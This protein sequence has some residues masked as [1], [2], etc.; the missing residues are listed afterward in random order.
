MSLTILADENM[1]AVEQAFAELGE[2]RTMPGR[3]MRNSDLGDVDVL[4]VRSVTRVD[5]QLLDGTPVRFVGTATSGVDHIRQNYL[6][7]HGIHFASAHGA[8]ANSVVEY[9]LAAI[10][11][12]GDNLEALLDGAS[13]GIIGHGA[14]GSLLA[15]R[16][17]ALGIECRAYD[18]WLDAAA[19]TNAA[20]LE[21]VLRSQVISVH[22][23]LSDRPPWPSRHL[24]DENRLS[25]LSRDQL[26]V[27]ASRGPVVDNRALVQLLSAGAGPVPV[28]DVWEQEP[29]IDPALLELVLLGTSHIAGYSYDSKVRATTM[30]LAACYQWLQ[31][32]QAPDDLLSEP[33]VVRLGELGE[34]ADKAALLRALLGCR[35]D[36]RAD[37]HA[38]RQVVASGDIGRGFDRLRKEYPRRRELAGSTISAPAADP[39]VLAGLCHALGCQSL[40]RP[41]T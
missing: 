31:R 13:V 5:S 7:A 10:A 40:E 8:N 4:L 26:L 22:A 3:D 17:L 33:P 20:T 29:D 16:L 1:P 9:V 34:P 28:L 30:L 39:G 25:G 2:V 19:V 27:N 38:L 23:E 21:E 12:V 11:A 35:Y 32:P 14:V 36:I 41:G 6:A 24:L 18:P 37:D 15:T